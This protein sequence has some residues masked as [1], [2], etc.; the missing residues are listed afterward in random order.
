ML[1]SHDRAL[2]DAVGSRT[3][4]LRDQKLTSYVGGWPEYLRVRAE[5]DAKPEPPAVK[6]KPAKTN[7]NGNGASAKTNGKGGNAKNG[8]GGAKP[9][10]GGRNGNGASSRKLEQQIESAEAQ[11]ATVEDELADPSAWATPEASARSTERHELAKQRVAELYE[12]YEAV[13]G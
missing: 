11:L 9:S 10:K 1:V 13:A 7:G 3:V 4:E 2:L 6:A 5:R 12:R 8:N